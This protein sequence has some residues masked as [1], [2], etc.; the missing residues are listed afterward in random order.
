MALIPLWYRTEYR[1]LSDEITAANSAD[2]LFVAAAGNNAS[3]N[4]S[5]PTYPASYTQANV[6]AVAASTNTDGLA[7][8]SNFGPTSVDLAAPGDAIL[9]TMPKWAPNETLYSDGFED[10]LGAAWSFS[11]VSTPSRNSPLPAHAS[12]RLSPGRNAC[13]RPVRAMFFRSR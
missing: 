9:S 12:F 13:S 7:A 3:N 11:N 1:R 10:P 8:F 5:A 2:V 4:D 6:I